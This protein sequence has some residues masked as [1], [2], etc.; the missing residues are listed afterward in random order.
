MR[1]IA[2]LSRQHLNLDILDPGPL[3]PVARWS[4]GT[5]L[6][7]AGGISL[8]M[9]FEPASALQNRDNYVILGVLVLAT[10]VIFFLSMWSTHRAMARIKAHELALTREHLADAIRK[11]RNWVAQG[12]IQETEGT[13]SAIAAWVAYERRI[14]EASEWPFNAAI[15]R[16]LAAS[17]LVPGGVYLIK[18][19]SGLGFRF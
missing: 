19:I 10:V 1:P 17:I 11:L 2:W 18:I 9:A 5:T 4:L 6:I 16:R 15:L 14:K 7:F 8:S 3:L 13:S 12:L